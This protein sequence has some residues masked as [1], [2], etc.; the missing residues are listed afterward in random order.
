MGIVTDANS[1]PLIYD[2]SKE[3][4]TIREGII[5]AKSKKAFDVCTERIEQTLGRPI[6]AV[7]A[8]IAEEAMRAR[9]KRGKDSQH[10]VIKLNPNTFDAIPIQ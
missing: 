6:A 8:E 1:R 2:D 5:V 4:F 3:N 9:E 7:H 10:K